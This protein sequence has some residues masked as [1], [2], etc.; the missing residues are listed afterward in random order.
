[1]PKPTPVRPPPQADLTATSV[2]MVMA[3]DQSLPLS[4]V[5]STLVQ[6]QSN[7]YGTNSPMY[8]TIGHTSPPIPNVA[9]SYGVHNDVL[10]TCI[11]YKI[12][13]NPL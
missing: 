7:A 12:L 8:S 10:P 2:Q 5:P 4:F 13:I 1:M 9:P 6:S 3:P 11:A